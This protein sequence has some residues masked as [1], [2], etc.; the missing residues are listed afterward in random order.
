MQVR[1][2]TAPR[3]PHLIRI[4]AAASLI[5]GCQRFY[6]I[7]WAQDGALANVGP[8]SPAEFCTAWRSVN[9]G[10]PSIL[11]TEAPLADNWFSHE[12]RDCSIITIGDWE[13]MYA[14]PSLRSYLIYEIAQ[15]LIHFA[16]DMSEEMAMNM[17]H[18]P[19]VG[20]IYDM[21]INKPDIRTSP[22]RF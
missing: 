11:V 21:T 20:C 8:I 15:S 22:L 5:N 12:Y 17:V 1:L 7:E 9:E 10:L 2:I 16:A 18:E 6:R 13:Q 4:K 19:A 14:P 3:S